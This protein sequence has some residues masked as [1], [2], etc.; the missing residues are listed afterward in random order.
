MVM[1][2]L[3]ERN[4]GDYFPLVPVILQRTH[5]LEYNQDETTHRSIRWFFNPDNRLRRSG[6]DHGSR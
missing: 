2:I 1:S 3:L 6:G 5:A 4:R